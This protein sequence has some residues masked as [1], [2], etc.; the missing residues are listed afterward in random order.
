MHSRERDA[1]IRKGYVSFRI[2]ENDRQTGKVAVEPSR[3]RHG[4]GACDRLSDPQPPVLR[5]VIGP[6]TN[7]AIRVAAERVVLKGRDWKFRRIKVIACVES[8]IA[9]ETVNTAMKR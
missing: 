7:G 3:I 2:D 8:V 5:I 9:V 4:R 1:I 6:S